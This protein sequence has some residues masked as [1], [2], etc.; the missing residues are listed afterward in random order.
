MVKAMLSNAASDV[1][2]S[3][4]QFDFTF[5][6]PAI[7]MYNQRKEV[8]HEIKCNVSCFSDINPEDS[9]TQV[10]IEAEADEETPSGVLFK[11]A[12]QPAAV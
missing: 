12:W 11:Q 6:T 10:T 3:S 2:Q 7:I 8:Q 5:Y 9:F 4:P 1:F